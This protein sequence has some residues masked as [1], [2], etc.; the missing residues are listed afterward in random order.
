MAD[1]DRP[2]L[3]ALQGRARA[4]HRHLEAYTQRREAD[5]SAVEQG[6]RVVFTGKMRRERSEWESLAR[7]RGLV[8]GG[9][10]RSTRVVVAADP[11]SQSGKAAK[12]RAYRVPIISEEAWERIFMG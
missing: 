1:M 12:A 6:D 9:V 2:L 5:E 7:S 10:T 8:P 3:D 11:N 4:A